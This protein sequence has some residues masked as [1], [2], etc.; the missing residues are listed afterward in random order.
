M[1]KFILLCGVSGTGKTVLAN[2]L[3][4]QKEYPHLFFKK[5]DQVTT[6]Q[7]R[8]DETNGVDYVFLNKE[9]YDDMKGN[10]IAKTNFYENYYGTID[11]SLEYPQNGIYNVN[12]IIVNRE[13]RDASVRD[14][15]EKY[16]EDSDIITIQVINEKN[17][18]KREGRN[19]EDLEKEKK[20]L[21]EVTDLEVINNTGD[22]LTNKEFIKTLM[23]HNFVKS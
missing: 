1:K 12:I 18:V 22:W 2:N 11:Q 21:D 23:K 10:L 16:G 13:G 7:Q 19:K 3:S 5:L 9:E 20:D 15:K 6:R 17:Q 8:E 4:D 14:I